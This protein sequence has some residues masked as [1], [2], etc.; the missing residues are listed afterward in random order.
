MLTFKVNSNTA[1]GWGGGR[2]GES[3]TLEDGGAGE[4]GTL[5]GGGG[6]GE[7]GNLEGRGAGVGPTSLKTH[8]QNEITSCTNLALDFILG[9]L[10]FINPN[11][12]IFLS[13]SLH[14]INKLPNLWFRF[15]D[16]IAHRHRIDVVQ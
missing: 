16:K 15:L 7:G 12:Q 13:Q 1:W 3:G 4:G 10:G 8:I 6:A 5:E 11:L 2:A 9:L 14:L